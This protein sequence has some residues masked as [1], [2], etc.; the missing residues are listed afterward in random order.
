[1][2][3]EVAVERLGIRQC[4]SGADVVTLPERLRAFDL[5]AARC[6]DPNE[7]AKLRSIIDA[8]GASEFNDRIR[9]IGTLL[10]RA[11]PA[12]GSALTF[13]AADSE[14]EAP[15]PRAT[16]HGKTYAEEEARLHTKLSN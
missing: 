16:Q 8:V 2:Q 1:M 6:Y 12:R 15:W 13:F 10:E 5:R 11:R 3:E 7:E 14:D 4:Y 9:R